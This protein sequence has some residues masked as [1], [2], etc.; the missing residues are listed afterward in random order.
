MTGHIM[1]LQSLFCWLEDIVL[2]LIRQTKVFVI[3]GQVYLIFLAPVFLTCKSRFIII[4]P[5]PSGY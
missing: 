2:V 5:I 3:L 1:L 4:V